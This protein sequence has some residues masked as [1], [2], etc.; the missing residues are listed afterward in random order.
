[1]RSIVD[2]M[3]DGDIL[4][5]KNAEDLLGAVEFI[6]GVQEALKEFKP[7]ELTKEEKIKIKEEKIKIKQRKILQKMANNSYFDNLHMKKELKKN[8]IILKRGKTVK[9]SNRSI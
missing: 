8:G 6:C 7:K 5:K 4:A 2:E 9:Q 3:Q 1:M